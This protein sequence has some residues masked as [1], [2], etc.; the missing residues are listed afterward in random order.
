MLSIAQHHAR[1]AS[2]LHEPVGWTV[3][4]RAAP[5]TA[6]RTARFPSWLPN[7]DQLQHAPTDVH[8]YK[9]ERSRHEIDSGQR[10]ELSCTTDIFDLEC[11]CCQTLRAEQSSSEPRW[12][13]QNDY[14]VRHELISD[15]WLW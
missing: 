9:V 4:V 5:R 12:I 10:A 3:S 15:S 11:E 2:E 7:R 1:S 6:V 8:R 13:M 14:V